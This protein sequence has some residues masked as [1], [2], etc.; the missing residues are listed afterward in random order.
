MV[1]IGVLLI[2]AG[3]GGFFYMRHTKSE[4]HAMIGTETLSIPQLEDN[5]RIS[6]EL[7]ARGGFRKVSEVVGAAHPR[8]EGA[9]VSEISKTECVWYRYEIRR[10]YE[11]VQYRDGR[12]H[13]SK[14]M[15]RV[16]EHTSSAGYALID[17]Q[18]RTIGVDPN[19]TKPEGVEQTVSRFEP[20][21]GNDNQSMEL[22]GVR[23]PNFLS[24][25]QNSTIGF[26]YKEWV[27]RPRSR[28]YILG[29]VHDKIGPLVIGRPEQG[30]H[31]IIAT[32]TE[33]ELRHSR[34]QRH[35]LLSIGVIAATVLGLVVTVIGIVR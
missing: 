12:R 9:L 8:P 4:L 28:M 7:G 11:R 30:G 32:K 19:G 25:G 18:G 33:D 6:D 31:F 10:Q 23:L 3:V 26:E 21:S 2:L 16:A 34:S 13:Y 1:I 5:R 27:I 17:D 14:H 15:E 35:R 24:S 29:E 20:S 22:F